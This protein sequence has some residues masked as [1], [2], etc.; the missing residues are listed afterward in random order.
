VN[1]GTATRGKHEALLNLKER[2]K[3]KKTPFLPA[4][5]SHKVVIATD[6]H[7]D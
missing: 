6:N 3:K 1:L 4:Q 5:M 2:K 7:E